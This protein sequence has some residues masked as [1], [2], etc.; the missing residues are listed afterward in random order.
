MVA[1]S[2]RDAV[3]VGAELPIALCRALWG[4]PSSDG[5]WALVIDDCP[6]CQRTHAH[7]GGT[8]TTP[9]LGRRAAHCADITVHRSYELRVD[10]AR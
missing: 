4:R 8:G 6:W 5:G 7:G 9:V 1:T 2:D 3:E 10:G